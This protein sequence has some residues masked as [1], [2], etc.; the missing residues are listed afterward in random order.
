MLLFVIDLTAYEEYKTK[1][2]NSSNVARRF[3]DRKQVRSCTESAEEFQTN[4][5]SGTVGVTNTSLPRHFFTNLAKLESFIAVKLPGLPLQIL[6]LSR[7]GG[8]GGFCPHRLWTFITLLISK[9]KPPNLVTSLKIYLGT[10]W[11]VSLCL[12][13]LTLPWQPLFDKRFFFQNFEFPSFLSKIIT[14]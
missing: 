8:E 14:F 7:P 3:L 4:R 1:N 10:I 11:V 9:L 5:T 2:S 6:T 12:L 13:S